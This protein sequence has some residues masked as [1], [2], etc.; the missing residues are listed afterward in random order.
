MATQYA[1]QSDLESLT[2]PAATITTW[3]ATTAEINAALL[4][5]S[6]E[7]DGYLRQRYDLPLTSYDD[8]MFKQ[9]I[10]D[11]GAFRLATKKNYT[12]QNDDT[13]LID[14]YNRAIKWL[15]KVARGEVSPNLGDSEGDE[16]GL[17]A[18][19]VSDDQREW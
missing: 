7:A 10:C 9:A 11:I 12:T 2:L 19:I 13:T 17:M 18:D 4:A 1:S 16:A 14:G 5:A 6:E 15:T 8:A 3:S